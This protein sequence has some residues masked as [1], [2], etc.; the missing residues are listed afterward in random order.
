[1]YW[2]HIN[3]ENMDQ[4]LFAIYRWVEPDTFSRRGFL[5][6]LYDLSNWYDRYTGG[7]SVM[8]MANENANDNKIY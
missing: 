1:M 7:G 5:N 2:R 8:V 6:W 3:S 4:R